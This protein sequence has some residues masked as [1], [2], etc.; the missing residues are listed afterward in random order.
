MRENNIFNGKGV[1]EASQGIEIFHH[2][3]QNKYKPC[4][5]RAVAHYPIL[6]GHRSFLISW[7]YTGI[8][9]MLVKTTYTVC[10][11]KVSSSFSRFSDW[12]NFFIGNKLSFFANKDI[13]EGG[14]KVEI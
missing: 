6:H 13:F 8:L 5:S 1:K 7:F 2:M 3:I 10:F 12:M 9:G 4:Y 14:T 11:G